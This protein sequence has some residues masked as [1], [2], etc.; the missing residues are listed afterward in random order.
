MWKEKFARRITDRERRKRAREQDLVKRRSGSAPVEE[1]MNEDEAE[2][3]AEEDDEEVSWGITDHDHLWSVPQ[4]FRRLMILQIR[5]AH[6]AQLVSLETETGG[7]DTLLPDFWEEDLAPFRPSDRN[8]TYSAEVCDGDELMDHGEGLPDETEEGRWASEAAEAEEAEVEAEEVELARQ[9][10][11]AF[12]R[13][14]SQKSKM[15]RQTGQKA[16]ETEWDGSEDMEIEW[17]RNKQ[18]IAVHL[19]VDVRRLGLNTSLC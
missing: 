16:M 5:K 9:A 14:S 12:R 17:H 10:E 6:H 13:G 8:H 3:R 7:S 19:W 15:S 4:I 1:E 2:R 18:E 11:E